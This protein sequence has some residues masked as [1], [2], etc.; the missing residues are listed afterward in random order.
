MYN[1]GLKAFHISSHH[2][3]PWHFTR[4]RKS[5]NARLG[6]FFVNHNRIVNLKFSILLESVAG[7]TL[8]ETAENITRPIHSL[9][10]IP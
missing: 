4:P 9:R 7:G 6:T 5:Q 10:S 3:S 2:H 1:T 8:L